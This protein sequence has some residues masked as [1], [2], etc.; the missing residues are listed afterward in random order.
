[1]WSLY[2]F[3]VTRWPPPP[4]WPPGRAPDGDCGM[5]EKTGG[6]RAA[7]VEVFCWSRKPAS[8]PPV[9]IL[10]TASSDLRLLIPIEPT[11]RRPCSLRRG[12][13]RRLVPPRIEGGRAP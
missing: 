2:E 8:Y 7:I 6:R 5:S 3:L 12:G 1:M 11:L 10:E 9:L 4:G 13:R